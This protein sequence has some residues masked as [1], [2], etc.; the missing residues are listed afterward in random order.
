MQTTDDTRALKIAL[1]AYVL[2][3]AA[4]LAA[5]LATDVMA[6]LAET[7]HTLS[8]LFVTG[9]LLV[10]AYY[11]RRAADQTHMFGYGRAQNIAALTAATLFIS[12]TS[13]KLY[14]QAVPR[15]FSGAAGEYQNLNLALAVI[16]LSML[17]AAI[18]LINLYRQHSRG[19]SAKAQFMGLINDEFGLLAALLGTLFILWGQPLADPVAALL[20]ATLIA[21][22]GI[23]LFKENFS[24]LLGRSPEQ[25]VL[26][27]IEKLALSVPGV[28]GVHE[29]R[30]E[31]IGPETVHIGLHIEV[32]GRLT[33]E[34]ANRMAEEVRTRVHEGM[35]PGY[36]YIHVDAA[37]APSDSQDQGALAPT[38]A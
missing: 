5:Y 6:M 11:S 32:D 7:L 28:I 25:A 17:I 8:D 26:D 12:F 15:L 34:R 13:Y 21:Y 10:A 37:E 33:V 24:I 23:K 16:G 38:R 4:K 18:P 2:V 29:L 9:F 3:L 1:G 35:Q 19:A 27:K 36:C 20:V 30:A 31:F 14:E 22:N